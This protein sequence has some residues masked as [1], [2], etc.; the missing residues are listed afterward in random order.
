MYFMSSRINGVTGSKALIESSV[1]ILSP[2][3]KLNLCIFFE[4]SLLLDLEQ[5]YNVLVQ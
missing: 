5:Y 2:V 1:S 4:D 3:T